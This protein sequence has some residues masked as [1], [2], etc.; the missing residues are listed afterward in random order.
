MP[1]IDQP[2]PYLYLPTRVDSL[3]ETLTKTLPLKRPGLP[4]IAATKLPT[5]TSLPQATHGLLD[6]DSPVI[7]LVRDDSFATTPNF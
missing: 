1:A 5:S 7:G 2:A 4:D 3:S 6:L